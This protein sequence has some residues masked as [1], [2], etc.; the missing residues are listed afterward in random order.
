MGEKEKGGREQEGD[1]RGRVHYEDQ[2]QWVKPEEILLECSV[3][4]LELR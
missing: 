3:S 1:E 4:Y 2:A